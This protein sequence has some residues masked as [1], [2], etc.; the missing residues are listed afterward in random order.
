M[1]I[2]DDQDA[3]TIAATVPKPAEMVAVENRL[4]ALQTKETEISDKSRRAREELHSVH[5]R[6]R[7]VT[8]GR[9]IELQTI[10]INHSARLSELLA[11]K[12]ECERILE[13]HRPAYAAAITTA[14]VPMRRAAA[15]RIIAAV[16]ELQ[17]AAAVLD[18]TVVEI[19]RA[20]ATPKQ[21]MMPLLF[22]GALAASAHSILA[23][24][25][26]A[27]KIQSAA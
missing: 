19:K 26:Q 4:R 7:E 18:A 20:G 15:E 25:E 10:Q 17:V 13:A 12:R 16:A 14:L 11:K 3:A 8:A 27:T 5:L 21:L 23:E 9:L 1:L 22:L 2:G 24:A 6:S